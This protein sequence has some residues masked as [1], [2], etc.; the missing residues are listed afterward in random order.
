VKAIGALPRAGN[1]PAELTSFIG[2]RA[3]IA[4]LKRALTT[5]RM[6]TMTGVGG[7]GKS[8]LAIR[9][10]AAVQR[11]FPQGV[12][13]VELAGVQD[14]EL[15][16]HTVAHTLG[17]ADQ[18]G[19]PAELLADYVGG[20]R[21]LLVMDNCEHL[22]EASA[23]LCEELLHA[24]PGVRVLA[25]SREALSV[26][27]ERVYEVASLQAQDTETG[28]SDA[29]SLFAQRGFAVS[30]NFR[31][32]TENRDSVARLCYRLDGLPLAIELAAVW[33]RT[34][35]PA[36]ILARLDDRFRLLTK[37]SRGAL[38]RHQTL[39]A[40]VDW[41]HDLC[42]R[43]EQLAWAR[44]SV[45]AGGFDLAAAEA[46]CAG[47]D[48]AAGDV[49]DAVEGL[50][51]KSVL[52]RAGPTGQ[53]R[54]QQLETI[55]LYGQEKLRDSGHE[56]AV[57]RLHRD[58]YLALAEQ[59]DADWF[60]PRQVWWSRRLRLE[61]PNL[62]AA[63][64]FCLTEPGEVDAGLRLAAGLRNYWTACGFLS[65]GVHWLSRLLALDATTSTGP[66]HARLK[67][68]WAV[69]VL[70][71][72][73][74]DPALRAAQHECLEL[75]E[76]LGDDV[77]R[78]YVTYTMAMVALF[79]GDAN[80]S[81]RLMEDVQ[82]ITDGLAAPVRVDVGAIQ[83][84]AYVFSG[85]F[86]R[87]AAMCH[88]LLAISEAHGDLFRRSYLLYDL[89]IAAYLQRDP[90][91]AATH[92]SECVRL[93]HALHD[94]H[95]I[96]VTMQVLAWASAQA[97]DFER[98]AVVLGAIEAIRSSLGEARLGSS[99]WN[100]PFDEAAAL[101]RDAL[102]APVFDAAFARGTE[103]SLD[104]AVAAGLNV[105]PKR[106]SSAMP[107]E[108]PRLTAR[109]HEVAG[110]VADGMS[111]RQVAAALVIS[112]RTA[113]THVE[114]I[115]TKLGFTSRAEIAAWV[116]SNRGRA[117]PGRTDEPTA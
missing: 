67:A 10:G 71:T 76:V 17:L 56:R 37:G 57:Q 110:L 64:G 29:M 12:W 114:N 86:D 61:H 63:L 98:T 36:Q 101:A 23:S 44:V 99:T 4:E 33:L 32:R 28:L 53:V 75:A 95:G 89:A 2:R 88:E 90:R 84:M 79:G 108:V 73:L 26:D 80:R 35:E 113:E 19:T 60:G 77:A 16:A 13:L 103:L 87:A 66:S 15:V 18:S 50:V 49:S 47:D 111:N 5:S 54:Y 115:L 8:R 74:G 102:D 107:Q 81:A 72:G 6:V 112:T 59:F 117:L 85:D 48:F 38:P 94:W 100:A 42:S 45:F 70:L 46:V 69:C 20:K 1:L 9:T 27:G 65:E 22:L 97:R 109:E 51:S 55:R 14:P 93:K 21:L 78:V 43:H 31:I 96:A 3:D 105:S 104:E 7:V 82:Q 39:R 83:A 24:G 62:R 58:W 106:M 41:S 52:G 116:N 11:E 92:A 91:A 68:L 40:A 30:S 25:T 34:L